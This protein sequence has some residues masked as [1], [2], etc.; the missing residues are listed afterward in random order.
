M[1]AKLELHLTVLN[2]VV[3]KKIQTGRSR[4]D[5]VLTAIRLFLIDKLVSVEL[6]TLSLARAFTIL[7][8]RYEFVP[9]PGYTHMQRAMPSSVGMWAGS[10]AE[11]LFDDVKFLQS[12]HA[13]ID[14][15]PL[16]SAAGYGS[17]L[18][19]DRSLAAELMGFS[20]VQSNSLYCQNSRGKFE[21]QIM[22]A[23]AAILSDVNRL[24][25]DLLLFTTKEFDFFRLPHNF[26]SGSS[27]MP[28]KNNL[29]AAELLRAKAKR[30]L[31]NYLQ[32]VALALDLPSGYNRDLQDMKRPLFDSIETTTE[33]VDIAEL[34]I[35]ALEP[36]EDRLRAACSPEIYST[37]RALSAVAQGEA[38]RDA[39]RVI[40]R[41][42]NATAH[43]IDPDKVL[44]ASEHLGGTGNLRLKELQATIE[45]NARATS[46]RHSARIDTWSKLKGD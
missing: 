33:S 46:A 35:S 24:A 42:P 39:Y 22:S 10:F 7:A 19:L 1:H 25:S 12:I 4:N 38:F 44:R 37:H 18:L 26:Y 43:Q 31:G 16:G 34:I 29:D 15:S 20:R 5:Q 14:C 23:F 41:D 17:P 45:D 30:L 28:Q 8:M 21:A 27:I 9:M 11:A 6:H 3:G 2:P 32:V 13:I 40:A 36:V